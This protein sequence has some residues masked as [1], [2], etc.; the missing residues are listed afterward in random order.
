MMDAPGHVPFLFFFYW[1]FSLF[2]FQMLSPSPVSLPLRNTLSHPPSPCFYEGVPPPTDTILHPAL[3]SPTPLHWSIY[4]AF[5]GPRTSPPID[6]WQGHPLLH[7][8]LEPCVLLGWWL[9][10][11]ELWG[12]WLVDIVVL[13][14]GLQTPSAPSV[15][16]LT[17][18]L[19]LWF[20]ASI[21]LCIYKTLA[22]LLRRPFS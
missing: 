14:M 20:P 11:F 21:C 3:H 2:T 19:V 5:I 9:S 10:H 13:P 1:T 8:Q 4:Q 17:L 22:G 15:V 7:M 16:S 18:L 6:A 12:I